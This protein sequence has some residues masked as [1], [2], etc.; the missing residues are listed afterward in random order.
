[1]DVKNTG[2]R[3]GDEVFQLCLNDQ[4]SSVTR[5]VIELKGFEKVALAP[6][7][8][9]T[10]RFKLTREDLSFLDETLKRIVEP[11]VFNVMVGASSADIRLRGSFSVSQ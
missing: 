2:S 3:A 6:G 1:M 7:E 9:K 11:G 10:V 4:V 5:P 8:K